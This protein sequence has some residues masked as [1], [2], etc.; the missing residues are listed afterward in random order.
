MVICG[1]IFLMWN[2]WSFQDSMDLLIM[3]KTPFL[4]LSSVFWIIISLIL[5][6]FQLKIAHFTPQGWN[7]TML[8]FS[9][10]NNL[11]TFE[12]KK[13]CA[14]KWKKEDPQSLPR[15]GLGG[16]PHH[17]WN[18]YSTPMLQKLDTISLFK[19]KPHGFFLTETQKF[20]SASSRIDYSTFI[21][22]CPLKRTKKW[23]L[24]IWNPCNVVKKANQTFWPS[25][26]TAISGWYK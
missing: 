19:K 18:I 11:A 14:C 1:L 24:F 6:S 2:L 23:L 21:I 8:F 26:L 7:I 25:W 9:H 4:V 5:Y 20:F 10:K 22:M 16:H 3:P 12:K 17:T 13:S 15:G